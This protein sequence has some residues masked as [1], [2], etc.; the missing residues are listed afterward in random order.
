MARPVPVLLIAALFA[1]CA[2][3]RPGPGGRGAPAT[4]TPPLVQ[5]ID[6]PVP[7]DWRVVITAADRL[8]LARI[9]AA[10]TDGLAVAGRRFAAAIRAEGALLDPAAALPRPDPPP[11]P[12]RC[13]LVALAAGAAGGA[14]RGPQP[15]FA[16]FRPWDCY[17]EAEGELLTLVKQTGSS[18]PAGRLWPDR[19]TRLVFLGAVA[20]SGPATVATP[21]YAENPA[22]DLAG[23]V[24]RVGPFRWRLAMPYPA[25][26]IALHVYELVPVPPPG[27]AMRPAAPH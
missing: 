20:R 9:D 14:A 22:G 25:P 1:G 2:A 15:G 4:Q 27:P 18:R 3:P 11:G 26:G 5:M 12:Y 17:V 23:L 24:E 7:L 21:A 6:D 19:P 16:A 8:R 10:W 13:R